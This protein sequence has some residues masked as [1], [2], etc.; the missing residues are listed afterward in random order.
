MILFKDLPML[1]KNTIE[2]KFDYEAEW[3]ITGYIMNMNGR[4]GF[5]IIEET[6]LTH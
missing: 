5:I 6:T 4:L 1:H 2:Y 3:T